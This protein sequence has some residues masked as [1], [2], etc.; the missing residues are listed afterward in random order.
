[1]LMTLPFWVWTSSPQPTA[2]NGQMVVEA[3]SPLI[4]VT[5]E[6]TLA[7]PGLPEMATPAAASAPPCKN[8]LRDIPMLKYL[9][10]LSKRDKLPHLLMVKAVYINWRANRVY[11]KTK[12][13]LN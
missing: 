7:S 11:I 8:C 4:L 2:Q 9:L 6:S 13:A 1:M 3:L 10:S 12:L 5:G